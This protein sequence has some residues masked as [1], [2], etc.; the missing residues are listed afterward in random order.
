M[1]TICGCVPKNINDFISKIESV[2]GYSISKEN[3]F[4]YLY[5]NNF[6]IETSYANSFD[7][8]SFSIIQMYFNELPIVDSAKV[9]E[10][11]GNYYSGINYNS[12]VRM[13]P[14]W[15]VSSKPFNLT[16]Y[17]QPKN[18]TYD[19]TAKMY[20]FDTN[21]INNWVTLANHPNIT[22]KKVTKETLALVSLF[23]A[24]NVLR[25][26]ENVFEYYDDYMKAVET[27]SSYTKAIP[28]QI[29]VVNANSIAKPL[30]LDKV[31]TNDYTSN[32][33]TTIGNVATIP[34]TTT[35]D[36]AITNTG[37]IANTQTGA[38][39]VPKALDIATTK[40][41]PV[42]PPLNLGTLPEFKLPNINGGGG[43]YE[44]TYPLCKALSKK[45]YNTESFDIFEKIKDFKF[46]IFG[47]PLSYLLSLH[48]IYIDPNNNGSSKIKLGFYELDITAP[49]VSQRYYTLNCGT[50]KVNL[51]DKR[52]FNY[53]PYTTFYIYLPFIGIQQI[54][55][56]DFIEGEIKCEYRI[57]IYTGNCVCFL[58]SIKGGKTIKNIYSG[59]CSST[60]PLS[61]TNET[62]TS[63]LIKGAISG[64]ISG[65]G[66]GA[67][68][69][70]LQGVL[71]G[72]VNISTTGALQSNTGAMSPKKPYIII[73]RPECV[74][75][76]EN[77]Q[78]IGY[79]F[80]NYDMIKNI[81]GY[82]K[83]IDIR[84][85]SNCTQL[86]YNEII[87]LLKEGVIV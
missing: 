53:A 61:Y 4:L 50:I 47:N 30:T 72:G 21:K 69:G 5:D 35:K 57:D 71:S 66:V 19:E 64:A 25:I 11:W 87:N 8:L 15:L 6:Y 1:A 2:I 32:L 9:T 38:I 33:A 27:S 85:Q 31:I 60:L 10:I 81:V 23:T 28:Y 80:Y 29:E 16:Y 43:V 63:G 22:I 52:Y 44:L 39:A 55:I 79:P 59:N 86:E 7:S 18:A 76:K 51:N 37:A 3:K 17:N 40:T 73:T 67:G 42:N 13:T 45:L 65:G 82:F 26:S 75:P 78:Y 34:V 77:T 24:E 36:I 70:A 54:N 12:V 84:L 74:S 49:I 48:E 46:N 62:F 58:Y 68:V 20:L 14:T 56:N 41:L 83:V